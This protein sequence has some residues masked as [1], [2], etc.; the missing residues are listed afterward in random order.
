MSSSQSEILSTKSEKMRK[1]PKL[2]S[3]S[4]LEKTIFAH[5]QKIPV[6]KE[7]SE[8][9]PEE[10]VLQEVRS[11]ILDILRN[12]IE[13]YDERHDLVRNRH[14]FSVKELHKLIKERI[15]KKIKLS[16]VY[17]HL[18]QLK[19]REF[20]QIVTSIKEGRQITHYYGRTAKLF[21][22]M[23]KEQNDSEYSHFTTLM[24]FFNPDI[25]S[26]TVKELFKS[27]LQI[28]LEVHNRVKM[29]ME[30]NVDILTELNVDTRDFYNFLK[31]IDRCNPRSIE[32]Y[33]K[34]NELLN[35]PMDSNA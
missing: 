19:D 21:L 3:G 31:S 27:L 15:S 32:V 11:A 14:V 17:F 23:G 28:K 10:L 30:N 16:N 26:E 7:I 12:G 18:N 24:Q 2:I 5:W 33:N 22:W 4:E 20:V 8:P 13:E 34:I 1:L 35:F 9:M 6:I 29:W 25:T